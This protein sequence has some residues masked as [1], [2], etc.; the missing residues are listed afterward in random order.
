MML[1]TSYRR[2][3]SKTLGQIDAPLRAQPC[4]ER[5]PPNGVEIVA[6]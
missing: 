6:W 4:C 1:L 5:F 3:E 2:H